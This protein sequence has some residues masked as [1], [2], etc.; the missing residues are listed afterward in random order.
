M[1]LFRKL[2]RLAVNQ[3]ADHAEHIAYGLAC[4]VDLAPI[5][6]AGDWLLLSPYFEGD[7][8]EKEGQAWK[9]YRQ[10]VTKAH[11]DKLATAFNALRTKQGANFRG[12]P[13]YRGHPDADK[14]QWPNEERLGGVMDIEARADGIYVKTAWNDAGEANRRNGYLVYPSPAWPYDEALK[15]RTGRIE[16]V[17]LRSIG[18]TNTPRIA[19][20]AAWTNSK[21]SPDQPTNTDTMTKQLLCKILGLPDTATDD[22]INKAA[23]A[24]I[25]KAG[26]TAK[27]AANAQEA[28]DEEKKKVVA[29]NALVDS[30]KLA[31]N[32][33]NAD[34]ERFRKLAINS[35]LDAAINGGRLT[36]AERPAF[37]VKFATN[38]DDADKELKT[39]AAAIN[40]DP[41]RLNKSN[42]ADLSTP[43]GRRLAFNAKLDE[44]MPPAAQGGKGL[45][46][47]AA[48]NTI[49]ATPDGAA[50]LK[51]MEP[52]PAK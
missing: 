49:K 4:N 38:F 15:Q 13:I 46:M 48:I 16:P 33:A 23:E 25:A 19:E 10:V 31:L 30:T 32:S 7:Y 35:Q 21:P 42:G 43:N 8:W 18:M 50:L 12:L 45:S 28:M 3:L 22:E 1:N 9:K 20:S 11:G 47:D 26:E 52:E 27:S 2:C 5:G 29:A 37:E 34:A 51:A 44:L 17:E 40:M 36:A 41:L 24:F 39:K 6:S 14:T